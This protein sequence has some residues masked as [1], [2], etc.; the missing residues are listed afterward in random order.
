MGASPMARCPVKRFVVWLALAL[1]LG[2]AALALGGAVA[3]STVDPAFEALVAR[4]TA[5]GLPEGKIRRLFSRAEMAFSPNAMS[6]KLTAL[7]MRKY[8]LRLVADIQTRLAALGY[9]AASGV[10]NSVGFGTYEAV[11]AFQKVNG[12]KVDGVV[13]PATWKALFAAS[14]LPKPTVTP[15][16]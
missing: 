15:K 5:D 4:L 9:M 14:A 16:P 8:G 13:G 11:R 2:A 7:Y 3:A 12:L 6:D 10:D 1:G